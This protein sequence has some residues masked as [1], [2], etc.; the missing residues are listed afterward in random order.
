MP[1][2]HIVE[3]DAEISELLSTYLGGRGYDCV[4]SGDAETAQ[5]RTPGDFD[6]VIVDVMLP[7]ADGLSFCRWLRACS[8]VPVIILS[9][10]KGDTE[11]IAGLELGA[12]DYLEKPFNP[13][14]LLA[15]IEALL[16]RSGRPASG[17][18]TAS[19]LRFDGWQMDLV[20]QKLQGPDG[21]HVPLSSAEY[22]LLALLVRSAPDPVRRED[23]ARQVL[24]VEIGPEDRRIDILVSRLRKKF[25]AVDSRADFVRTV[26]HQGYQFCAA[27]EG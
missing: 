8:D 21:I 6:A 25:S 7:G 14:E 22:R 9:A 16:R 11:R 3:D 2:I 18:R 23:I 20:T 26:R 5:L 15:R 13:R 12:D 4:L 19:R 27:L 1:R 24:D 10:V 17:G